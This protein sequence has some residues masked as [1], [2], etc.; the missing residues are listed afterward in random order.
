MA[1]QFDWVELA[2]GRMAARR[3][4]SSQNFHVYQQTAEGWKIVIPKSGV[5]AMPNNLN[6]DVLAKFG[7]P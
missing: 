3:K 5:L 6:G 7:T 4:G 2:P 1:P